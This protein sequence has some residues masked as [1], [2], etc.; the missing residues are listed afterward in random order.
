MTQSLS[1]LF[2]KNAIDN[3]STITID[4]NDFIDTSGRPLLFHPDGANA[5][6]KM[7]AWMFWLHHS[8]LPAND[9]DGIAIVDKTNGIVPQTSF[10]P[11]TFEIRE[12]ETQVR[13]EFNFS[14]YTTD[15]T[16]FDANS[17]V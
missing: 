2:G 14:I 7:A 8:Q 17:V 1:D 6:Q 10:I 12:D 15:N 16:P 4:V 3:G 5:E 13:H 9:A 11:K